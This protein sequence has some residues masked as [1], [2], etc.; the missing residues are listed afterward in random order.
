MHYG[1]SEGANDRYEYSLGA[2]NF[3]LQVARLGASG[4]RAG[5]MGFASSGLP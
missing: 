4:D 2:R 5:D 3:K 1:L